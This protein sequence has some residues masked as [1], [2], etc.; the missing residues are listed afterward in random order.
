[1]FLFEPTGSSATPNSVVINTQT[2]QS[3][4]EQIVVEALGR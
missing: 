2:M 4:E 1:M 3:G